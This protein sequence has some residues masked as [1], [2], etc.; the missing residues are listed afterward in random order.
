M[1]TTT[2][3]IM[4]QETGEVIGNPEGYQTIV[5]A[6]HARTTLRSNR[7][8]AYEIV[9]GRV[10]VEPAHCGSEDIDPQGF[11]NQCGEDVARDCSD[12]GGAGIRSEAEAARVA[13]RDGIPIEVAQ[14]Y[15]GTC[16]ASGTLPP[17]GGPPEEAE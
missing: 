7:L 13:A 2:Y 12:C 10:E 1:N 3:Y 16:E 9:R 14:G 15:C 8:P 6:K 5:A 17:F 4:Q 11:C